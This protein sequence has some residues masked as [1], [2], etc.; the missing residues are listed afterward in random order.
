MLA[1]GYTGWEEREVTVL[2][3]LPYAGNL[4]SLAPVADSP[5]YRFVQADIAD[6]TVLDKVLTG[7][8]VVVNLAAETDVDRSIDR[9]A[10]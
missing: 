5:R 6:A 1:D 8:D 2:D 3:K 10:G 4:A 7:H 9:P